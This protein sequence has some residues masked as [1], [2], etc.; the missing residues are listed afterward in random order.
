MGCKA[1]VAS[2]FIEHWAFG[3]ERW[4][5]AY[6]GMVQNMP[7]FLFAEAGIAQAVPRQ[8]GGGLPRF[9]DAAHV[10]A[11]EVGFQVHRVAVREIA[12][13]VGQR[14]P[15]GSPVRRKPM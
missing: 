11:N 14:R 4:A 3:V 12:F 9:Q 5:F 10:L 15:A 7:V 1:K 8:R 13:K 6:F 2:S